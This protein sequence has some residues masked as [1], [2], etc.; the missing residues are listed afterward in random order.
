MALK[1]FACRREH[2]KK[3]EGGKVGACEAPPLSFLVPPPCGAATHNM[4]YLASWASEANPKLTW[5]IE[6]EG[7]C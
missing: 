6:R 2:N 3:R 1:K 4:P 7:V 5:C